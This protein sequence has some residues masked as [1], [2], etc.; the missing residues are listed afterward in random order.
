MSL[1]PMELDFTKLRNRMVDRQ[2]CQRGIRSPTVL[3]AMRTV[4]RERFLPADLRHLAYEDS[5]LPIGE[6][7]TISQP[8]IVA[9]MA[10]ALELQGSER[11]LEVGTGSG[12]AAAVLAQLAREVYTVERLSP[13]AARSAAILAQLGYG[14][15]HVR[16]GDG[17]VGWPEHGPYEAI[18]VAAGGPWVPDSLKA[19]LGIDGRLVMPIGNNPHVQELVRLVRRGPDAY[20]REELAEVRFVPL[21]GEEGW[22]RREGRGLDETRGRALPF[23]LPWDR[24][25]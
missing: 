5:A 18:V 3:E 21:I 6:N 25:L 16:D 19:Q 15:I 7:Q 8:Y 10:E 22:P 24:G 12:Y 17:T 20:S 23:G 14:N 9:F 2:L 13:L 4:P 1:S 11:V